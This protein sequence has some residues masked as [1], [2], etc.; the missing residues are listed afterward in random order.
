MALFTLLLSLCIGL[1]WIIP[2]S[3]STSWEVYSLGSLLGAY[4]LIKHN[5]HLCPHRSP[6][7]LDTITISALTGPH[8]YSW[9]KRSNLWSSVLLKVTSAATGMGRIRTHILTTLA[10]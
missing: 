7:I 1:L 6:F 9:V 8:L 3:F 10:V 4:Q 2:G 5:N